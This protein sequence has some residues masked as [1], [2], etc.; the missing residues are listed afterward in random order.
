MI[1]YVITYRALNVCLNFILSFFLLYVWCSMVYVGV[2][3]VMHHVSLYHKDKTLPNPL[4]PF[5]EAIS[6]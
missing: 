4:Y 5:L 1:I 3:E 2:Q 6:F